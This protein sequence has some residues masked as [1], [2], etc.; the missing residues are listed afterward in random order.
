M[1]IVNLHLAYIMKVFHL[2]S[3]DLLNHTLYCSIN[4]NEKPLETLIYQHFKGFLY[5]DMQK[6]EIN[7]SRIKCL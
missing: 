7:E 3:C 2:V 1:Y 4:E 6:A 5:V